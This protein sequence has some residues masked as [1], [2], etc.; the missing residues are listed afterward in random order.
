MNTRENGTPTPSS[1]PV[2]LSHET[3]D[4]RRK[5]YAAAVTTHF[6]ATPEEQEKAKADPESWQPPAATPDQARLTVHYLYGRWFVAWRQVEEEGSLPPDRR[7]TLLRVVQDAE[8]RELE[9]H[10]V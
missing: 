9:Y 3:E 8:T 4:T 2:D 10:E 6:T 5:L 1:E 7:W